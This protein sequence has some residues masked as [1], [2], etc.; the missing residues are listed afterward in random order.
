MIFNFYVAV[1]DL[2][3]SEAKDSKSKQYAI[4]IGDTVLVNGEDQPATV[5]TNGK[6]KAKNVSIF[7]KVIET[8]ICYSFKT[9]AR[10]GS[11]SYNFRMILVL[12]MT[13]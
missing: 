3:N 2:T 13:K 11:D 12:P 9:K 1:S 7:L 5:L 8:L 4:C 6:K 10:T